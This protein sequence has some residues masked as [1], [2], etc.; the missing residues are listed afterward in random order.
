MTLQAKDLGV[1]VIFTHIADDGTQTMFAVERMV[2]WCAD[3]RQ[4]IYE[5][6]VDVDFAKFCLERRGIEQHRLNRLTA[7]D[8]IVPVLYCEWPDG[9]HLLVD[10]HHR[11]VLAARLGRK[12]IRGHVLKERQWRPFVVEGAAPVSQAALANTFSGIY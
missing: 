10:G 1:E 4:R 11:Y 2:K 8:L 7:L 9:S 6:P 5:T 3:T 12:T